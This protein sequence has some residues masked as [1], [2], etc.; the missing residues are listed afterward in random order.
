MVFVRYAFSQNTHTDSLELEYPNLSAAGKVA[1]LN[2]PTMRLLV[3]D[4]IPTPDNILSDWQNER[5]PRVANT[6]AIVKTQ[7]VNNIIVPIQ[8]AIA[9]IPPT[10]EH[11]VSFNLNLTPNPVVLPLLDLE[12][13]S[14]LTV[15][16]RNAVDVCLPTT[17]L[18]TAFETSLSEIR[19]T[20]TPIVVVCE[21][22]HI[23][24]P[25]EPSSDTMLPVIACSL[26]ALSI[27]ELI[28]PSVELTPP[29]VN[30]DFE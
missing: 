22:Y 13:N 26:N 17:S 21:S 25:V 23:P 18:P 12:S 29:K 15:E 19:I 8:L 2:P 24:A 20:I 30:V 4:D 27:P 1:T 3:Q 11:T 9:N 28:K 5:S 16:S 10:T 14:D 7:P 6:L